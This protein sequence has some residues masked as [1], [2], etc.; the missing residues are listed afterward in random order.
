MAV[1]ADHLLDVSGILHPLERPGAEKP[2]GRDDGN[3]GS[4]RFQ[5]GVA[6]VDDGATGANHVIVDDDLVM[7]KIFGDFLRDQGYSVETVDNSRQLRG[8]L[9]RLAADLIVLDLMLPGQDGLALCRK[10]ASSHEAHSRGVSGV[11][12]GWWHHCLG[13]LFPAAIGGLEGTPLRKYAPPMTTTAA[14]HDRPST[15]TSRPF[16]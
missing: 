4:S 12:L 6:G 16:I 1:R 2:V 3:R 13:A 9:D 8:A 10:Q 5:I 7:C 15:Q 14:T 11:R